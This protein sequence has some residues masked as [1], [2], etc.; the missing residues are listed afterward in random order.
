M[1]AI[2]PFPVPKSAPCDMV[3]R[4]SVIGESTTLMVYIIQRFLFRMKPLYQPAGP[5]SRRNV[6]KLLANAPECSK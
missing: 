5:R 6:T 1:F 3:E 2:R 4:V